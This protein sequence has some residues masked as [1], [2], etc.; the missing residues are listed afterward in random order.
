MEEQQQQHFVKSATV[1]HRLLKGQ[2]CSPLSRASQLYYTV[3]NTCGRVSRLTL[4]LVPTKNRMPLAQGQD[5]KSLH[6]HSHFLE[7]ILLQLSQKSRK[8]SNNAILWLPICW[9]EEQFIAM[10]E[11]QKKAQYVQ[12]RPTLK[13]IIVLVCEI[14][15]QFCKNIMIFWPFFEFCG[16][17]CRTTV[18]RM[19]WWIS[20][21]HDKLVTQV[22]IDLCLNHI[23]QVHGMPYTCTTW[24]WVVVITLAGNPSLAIQQLHVFKSTTTYQ[25][26]RALSD[27]HGSQVA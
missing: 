7:G 24:P 11:C 13:C 6:A 18:T 1:C 2:S 12:Q 23:I 14:F 9:G 3:E 4:Q 8:G 20:V 10:T 17:S 15:Q 25:M 5:V 26:A 27:D 22:Y 21:S 19:V 16:F